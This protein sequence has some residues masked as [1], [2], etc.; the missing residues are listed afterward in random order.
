[1]H[2]LPQD[3]KKKKAPACCDYP[4]AKGLEESSVECRVHPEK[5]S[6]NNIYLNI[7]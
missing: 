6:N 7:I 1:M 4:G 3:K 2:H 5:A